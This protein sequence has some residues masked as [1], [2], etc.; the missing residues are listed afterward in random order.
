MRLLWGV[1][2]GLVALCDLRSKHVPV[3]LLLLGLGI[4]IAQG[5]YTTVTEIA[6]LVGTQEVEGNL[7][8]QGLQILLQSVAAM[9]PGLCLLL[10][11]RLGGQAGYADGIVLL[12]LGL[13]SG[14]RESLLLFAGSLFLISAASIL[15]LMCRVV[16]RRSS[17]PY[18]PFLFLAYLLVGG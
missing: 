8:Q 11:A 1:Y 4:A 10:L 5:S 7:W 15:L 9:L 3:Q 2:L 18:L 14:V 17:L 12:E 16:S 6:E 13:T